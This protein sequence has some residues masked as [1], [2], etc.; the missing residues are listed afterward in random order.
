[1]KLELK[2]AILNWLINNYNEFNRLNNCITY[3]KEFIYD[4][5]GNYLK[6]GIGREVAEF[7]EKADKLLYGGVENE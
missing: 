3:F 2:Q 5:E 4:S 6:Y 7:I 1:M